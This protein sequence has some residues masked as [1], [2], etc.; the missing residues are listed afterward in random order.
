[1]SERTGAGTGAS[2][3]GAESSEQK[4]VVAALLRKRRSLIDD[5]GK[6]DGTV[7][8]VSEEYN[9]KLEELQSRRRPFEEALLHVDALLRLESVA[10][11]ETD[12]H[13]GVG[14]PA[15]TA[16]GGKLTDTAFEILQELRTPFHYKELAAKVLEKNGYIPG[17][18]PSATLLS[19]IVRDPRFK[20]TQKRGVY[21][22]STWRIRGA[23]PKSRKGRRSN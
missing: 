19:R 9:S 10:D 6:I 16:P 21:A 7:C 4:E 22:L 3:D 20:R 5:I 23:K 2:D 11:D 15:A 1:M 14:R 17:K 18:D 8:R 12:S 13:S